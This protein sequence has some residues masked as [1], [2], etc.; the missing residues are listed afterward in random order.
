MDLQTRID[1][2]LDQIIEGEWGDA[3][4]PDFV[5]LRTENYMPD[6]DVVI[7]TAWLLCTKDVPQARQTIRRRLEEVREALDGVEALLDTIDEAEDEANAAGH[8]DWAPLL[9]ILHAPIPLEKPE[10]YD[11]LFVPCVA[12]MLRDTLHD[13]AWEN[14]RRWTEEHGG[15]PQKAS[16]LPLIRSLQQ[17]EETYHVNLT[18]LL[19]SELDKAEHEAIREDYRQGRLKPLRGR[20][21]EDA[22]KP[23][24]K[25]RKSKRGKVRRR[26]RRR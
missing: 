18:D 19:F 15:A 20:E 12:V 25:R 4:G 1:I 16:D 14:Y 2:I 5:K 21:Q 24:G 7:P 13:A 22:G 8:S 3:S 26:R 9:A 10:V 6:A 17:F 11:P 23:S